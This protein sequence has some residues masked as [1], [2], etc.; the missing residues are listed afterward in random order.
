KS[1]GTADHVI[2]PNIYEVRDSAEDIDGTSAEELVKAIRE[3]HPSVSFGDGLENTAQT[4]QK[5]HQPYSAVILMGAGDV[6]KIRTMLPL[7][8]GSEKFPH[9]SPELTKIQ[10]TQ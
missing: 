4:L 5:T 1:F 7:K 6:W 10:S 3:N 9:N 8:D 2:I